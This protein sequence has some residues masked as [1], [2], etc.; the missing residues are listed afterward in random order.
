M[1]QRADVPLD[2]Q[3]ERELAAIDE[4]MAGRAV[5]PELADVAALAAALAE[6]RSTPEQEFTA[7]LDERAAAGFSGGGQRLPGAALWERIRSVPL[8]RRLMPIGATAFA[9]IVVATAVVATSEPGD[10]AMPSTAVS[11]GGGSA[12]PVQPDESA[13]APAPASA[14]AAGGDAGGTAGKESVATALDARADARRLAPPVAP[15]PSDPGPFASGE[16]RRFVERSAALTLGAEP[17]QVQQ[18]ADNIFGVVG[19]HNGIVL[20]SSIADGPEGQAG[21][22]FSLLIPSVR[23][24]DAL[25]DLSQIAEVRSRQENALDITAPVVTVRERL[26]DAR[27]EV[28]GLLKQLANADTDEER[29]AVKAQLEFQRQRVAGLRAAKNRLERRANLSRVQLDV[30]TGD[31][32]SFGSGE[33]GAWTIGDAVDDSGRILAVA[34]GVT[35]VGL[36]VLAPLALLLALALLGRRAWVRAGR[37]RALE[38]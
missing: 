12:A 28:E 22:Q 37:E 5:D 9:A 21:A 4:A 6:L 27:A 32:L 33:D 26:Q 10:D 14:P 20:S 36:A 18:V 31:A 16:R 2:P 30:V 35:L 29:A 17:E 38:G 24:D 19:R 11:G 23:L 3:A 1:R 34:A 13:P 8:R 25:A 15:A 7:E